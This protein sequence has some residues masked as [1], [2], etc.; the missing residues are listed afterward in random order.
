MTA[1]AE[2]RHQPLALADRI[3]C[4]RR[5]ANSKKSDRREHR[6]QDFHRAIQS[7][8]VARRKGQR[9]SFVFNTLHGQQVLKA[10]FDI[11][12]LFAAF[13]TRAPTALA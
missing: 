8:G 10:S 7:E 9:R 3:L 6:R 11:K 5:A 1:R 13:A 2:F 4:L 12:K